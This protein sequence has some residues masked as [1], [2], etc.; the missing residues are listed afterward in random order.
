MIK[1]VVQKLNY[2]VIEFPVQEKGLSKI[3]VKNGIF[4][5]VFIYKEVLVSSIYVSDQTFGE[6][7]HLLVLIDHDS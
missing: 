6:S 5:N 3:E 2:H 7:I 1:K 4:I